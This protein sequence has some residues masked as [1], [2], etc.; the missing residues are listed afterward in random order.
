MPAE[1]VS[2]APLGVGAR[3]ALVSPS[4]PLRDVGDL[5]RAE[6]NARLFGWDPVVGPSAMARH[7]YFAGPDDARLAD[8]Q[9]AIS[10][11]GIDG[12]W[13]VRGGYGAARL[14]PSLSVELIAAQPKTLIGYSDITA[15]HALW[16]RAGVCSYHGPTAR[17]TLT[18][19]TLDSFRRTVVQGTDG[20]GVCEQAVVLR[21]G[22]ATG[23]LAGGNLALVASLSGTPWAFDFSG[24]IVVLEDINEATYRV[25]RMLTQLYQSGAFTGCAGIAF[26]HCTNCD[27][28]SDDGARTLAEVVKEVA[29]AL[30]VP[31]VLGVP[32]GHIDDQW[33]L[34][35]GA[36][37]TLEAVGPPTLR[38]HD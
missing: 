22:V 6:A 20:A 3:I 1:L 17:G 11:P 16:R 9:A 15:L 2:P 10:D 28:Q 24:A 7:G 27:E 32:I 31:A 18:P 38:V 29:D 35:F 13:C 34:R 8:L 37:A 12:I 25:D 4:G 21:E 19:F 36:V 30:K 33:T 5:V 23:Q 14:L 26:G